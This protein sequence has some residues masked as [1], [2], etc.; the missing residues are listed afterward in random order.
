MT[1]EDTS[2]Y[3]CYKCSKIGHIATD[4]KCPQYKWPEQWHIFTAQVIDD[5]S[6]SDHPEQNDLNILNEISEALDLEIAKGDSIKSDQT[7]HKPLKDCADGSQYDGE[8]S[9]YE[10][11]DGYMPPLEDEEP[12]YI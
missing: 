1:K 5:R 6:E 8:E 10:E 11:Y 2:K 3:T 4:P 12:K 9:L 7:H